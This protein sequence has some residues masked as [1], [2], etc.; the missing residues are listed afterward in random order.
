M[1][2]TQSDEKEFGRWCR[3]GM[4]FEVQEW[5]RAGKPVPLGRTVQESP[6]VLAASNGFHR[7]VLILL[8]QGLGEA[9]TRL[10]A[11]LAASA[12]GGHAETC[13]LLLGRGAAIGAV[14]SASV[15]RCGNF[16]TAAFL[17]AAGADIKTGYPLALDLVKEKEAAY[18]FFRRFRR[19][20]EV[21]RQGAM[22]LRDAVRDG[23]EHRAT[24]FIRAGADPRIVVPTLPTYFDDGLDESS[25]LTDAVKSGTFRM[26]MRMR[27]RKSDV[28]SD[29]LEDAFL[30]I[31]RAKFVY[32]LKVAGGRANDVPGGGSALLHK[33]IWH[34]ADWGRFKGL[35]YRRQSDEAWKVATDLVRMGARWEPDKRELRHIRYYMCFVDDNRLVD[36]ARLLIEGRGASRDLVIKFFDTP[37]MRQGLGNEMEKIK[38]FV[39]GDCVGATTGGSYGGG[40]DE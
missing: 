38:S 34:L 35:H 22:A 29:L 8:G 24:R 32:L 20:K 10:D 5:L 21:R 17:M 16:E 13:R 18:A 25:A 37:K 3:E 12:A 9:Q 2:S 36:L 7:L 39:A 33:C 26:L 1:N 11:A 4:L 27:L 15:V 40:Q 14:L 19:I 28:T 23:E 30:N 6:L 31:N